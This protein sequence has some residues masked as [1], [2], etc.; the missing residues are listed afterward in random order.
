MVAID[1][2]A[3]IC[4]FTT[5]AERMVLKG[6]FLVAIHFWVTNECGHE[7]LLCSAQGMGI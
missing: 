5:G 7:P 2:H 6:A 4:F 1:N 3:S